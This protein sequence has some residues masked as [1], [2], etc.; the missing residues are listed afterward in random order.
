MNKLTSILL[1]GSGGLDD[2]WEAEQ[3]GNLIT[4]NA[5]SEIDH[6]GQRDLRK[7]HAGTNPTDASSTLRNTSHRINAARTLETLTLNSSPTSLYG[8]S[9]SPDLTTCTASS[10]GWFSGV[11][12]STTASKTLAEPQTRYFFKITAKRPLTP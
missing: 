3:F 4:A 12:N 5:T 10:S 1:G 6:D 11:E 9:S 7:F 8:I 2:G